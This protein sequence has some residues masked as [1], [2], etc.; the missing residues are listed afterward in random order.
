MSRRS[1]DIT[2]GVEEEFLVVDS[3]GRLSHQGGDLADEDH[4]VTGEFQRELVR[5]QVETTTPVC[6]DASDVLA[7]LVELRDGVAKRAAARG[8]R[9]VPSGT[10]VLPDGDTPAITRGHRYERMATWFGGV[11]HTSN[12]CGCHVHV[13][14]PD[15]AA[16]V[17]V[18]NQLRAWLPV[19]LALS[20]NSPFNDGTDTAYHSWRYVL[21]SR[22]PSAGPPPLFDSLDH[23]ETTLDALMRVGAV[24]DRRNIY[25]DIRLSEHQPTQEY[26]VCDVT[27]DPGTAALVAALI[28]AMVRMAL[29]GAELGVP[30]PVEILRANLWRSAREGLAGQTLHPLSGEMFPVR[31]QVDDLVRLVRSALRAGGDLDLVEAELAALDETGTGAHRQRAAYGRRNRL[32]DVVDD[33]AVGGR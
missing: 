13:G 18:G 12:T 21:W 26:R 31:R 9:I 14:M 28:R 10:P 15:R 6:Q 7:R 16:G 25:W 3:R 17:L 27:A 20:A 32:A 22:W 24:L 4:D 2:L 1:T 5:C 19:L 8:L 33:L 30:F 11:A 29:D 23:Y